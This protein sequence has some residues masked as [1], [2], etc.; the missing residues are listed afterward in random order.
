MP[1]LN[2]QDA[3]LFIQQEKIK[4]EKDYHF[5]HRE[6]QCDFL[7]YNPRRT[8]KNQG[9]NSI[10]EFLGTESVSVSKRVFCSYESCVGYARDNFIT[11]QVEW[12]NFVKQSYPNIPY[13]PDR[14]YKNSGWTGW[15]DFLGL[16]A[17][18]S[19]GEA[20]I[21]VF[22]TYNNIQF[23][24]QWK[25]ES[26]KY[27][28]RLAF[29]FAVFKND[30]LIALIE[31]QGQQHYQPLERWGG[32]SA[33]QDIITR[34]KIKIE[35]SEK[36]N[37][38]LL[39]LKDISAFDIFNALKECFT[40]LLGMETGIP[41]TFEPLSSVKYADFKDA[42]EYVVSL[43]FKSQKEYWCW[44]KTSD[45]PDNIPCC[46]HKV[47]SKTWISWGDYLGNQMIAAQFRVYLPFKDAKAWARANVKNTMEWKRLGKKRP[48]NIP[49]SPDS[50]YKES[51][52]TSWTDFI[53][54]GEL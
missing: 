5:W 12:H 43:K 21:R 48:K 7:P 44:A 30:V 23:T 52:W 27:K 1:Y 37:I 34:D 46:P 24:P 32:D 14:V 4:T 47:Y 3:K 19:R 33:Y 26:C 10:G 45:K 50:V 25:T 36:H 20:L 6:T 38:P 9:C 11:T 2:Y 22:L 53:G 49:S 42:R 31:Y 8:Y 54:I 28:N 17:H 16:D 40:H 51:G 13:N 35:W 39:I 29:D 41:K 18:R 15:T